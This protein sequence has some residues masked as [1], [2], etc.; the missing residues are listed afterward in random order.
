MFW[1]IFRLARYVQVHT[2]TFLKLACTMKHSGGQTTVVDPIS[3][4]VTF[5]MKPYTL[6]RN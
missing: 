1:L 3:A 4:R 5:H 6:Q 2:S